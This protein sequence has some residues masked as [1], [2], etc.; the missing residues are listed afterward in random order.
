MGAK[1][2]LPIYSN[3]A[4]SMTESAKRTGTRPNRREAG[5]YVLASVGIVSLI[6]ACY[7]TISLWI[8]AIV[9][10]RRL[11]LCKRALLESL[12]ANTLAERAWAA[13]N[14]FGGLAV[15]FIFLTLATILSVM[16]QLEIPLP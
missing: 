12:P 2:R 6:Y 1:R 10:L 11:S 5:I 3:R 7:W 8:A 4:L 16:V 14:Q 9:L 15:I 13:F